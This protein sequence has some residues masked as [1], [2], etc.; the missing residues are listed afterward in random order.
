M[1]VCGCNFN[2][3]KKLLFTITFSEDAETSSVRVKGIDLP[4]GPQFLSV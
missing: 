3:R 1:S 4:P 2:F